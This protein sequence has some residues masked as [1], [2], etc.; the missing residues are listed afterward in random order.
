M[1]SL[2][3][4]NNTPLHVISYLI[5]MIK[6][7]ILSLKFKIFVTVTQIVISGVLTR[8]TMSFTNAGRLNG[9]VFESFSAL[10]MKKCIDYCLSRSVCR[11]VNY[12]SRNQ[13]C[14]LN[15]AVGADIEHDSPQ[16]GVFYIPITPGFIGDQDGCS[17]RPCPPGTRCLIRGQGSYTC[18]YIQ[19]GSPPVLDRATPETEEHEVGST[20]QYQCDARFFSPKPIESLCNQWRTWTSVDDTCRKPGNCSDLK[21]CNPSYSDGEYWLYPPI[22]GGEK[23]KIYCNNLNSNE[24]GDFVTLYENNYSVL[25]TT[26]QNG[27]C[28]TLRPHAEDTKS[29]FSKI[30]VHTPTMTVLRDDYSF[31]TTTV[32]TVPWNKVAVAYG[33]GGDCTFDQASCPK[34]G[35]FQINT[36]GTGLIVDTGLFW[37]AVGYRPRMDNFYR[38]PDGYI[39]RANAGGRC[40]HCEP[41]GDITLYIK[42]DSQMNPDL[43]TTPIC[44]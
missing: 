29:H 24:P 6:Q 25:N 26:T 33:V 42:P 13:L 5:A 10:T 1:K 34:L 37:K 9:H 35:E 2:T 8:E 21:K 27:G 3:N 4:A 19:C 40:G 31:A 22:Y 32:I 36:M 20:L 12:Y 30:R 38:S 23:V 7:L 44:L 11:S 18:E 28:N 17:Q 41:N 14:E 43:A 39:I 16:L 15:R